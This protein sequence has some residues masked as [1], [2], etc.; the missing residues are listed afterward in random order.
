MTIETKFDVGD[1]V[2]TPAG[3]GLV[4]V[5]YIKR[6]LDDTVFTCRSTKIEYAV[7][8]GGRPRIF[9]ESELTDL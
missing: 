1:K 7:C 9:D 3:K 8:A 6:K 4:A 2:M 5:I